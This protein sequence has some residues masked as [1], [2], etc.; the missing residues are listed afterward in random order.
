MLAG[1]LYIADDP[2]LAADLRRATELM[3]SFNTG[4]SRAVLASLLGSLGEGAEVRPPLHVDYGYQVTI[5]RGTFLNFGAVLL[6]VAPITIGADVQIGPNVQLLTP[7]HPLDPAL[8]RARWEA[9]KPSATRPAWPRSS[10]TG[11]GAPR[12]GPRRPLSHRT[13]TGSSVRSS[14]G[15]AG[16]PP[17]PCR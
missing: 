17:H 8:R 12:A 10:E 5:G 1:E 14:P 13:T 6:D 4:G 16:S 9:A 2:E 3:S 15:A 7:T 11:A